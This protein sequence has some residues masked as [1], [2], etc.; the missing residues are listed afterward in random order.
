MSQNLQREWV[1]DALAWM[2]EW[3]D[4]RGLDLGPHVNFA[5][6]DG[7]K[8]NYDLAVSGLPEET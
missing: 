4:K 2:R 1:D 8:P 6:W 7:T 5:A 3:A